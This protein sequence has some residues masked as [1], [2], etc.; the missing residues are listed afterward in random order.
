MTIRITGDG[1][2]R[3]HRYADGAASLAPIRRA[4]ADAFG[5]TPAQTRV[6]VRRLLRRVL[7]DVGGRYVDITAA[8]LDRIVSLRERIETA[9]QSVL[10]GDGGLPA[11]VT[12]ADV[13]RWLD[14]LDREM[15]AVASPRRHVE[16]ADV[17]L[18]ADAISAARRGDGDADAPDIDA[19]SGPQIAEA[20]PQIAAAAADLPEA[21]R[22]LVHAAAAEDPSLA[23]RIARGESASEVEAARQRLDG[24]LERAGVDVRDRR[25][26]LA[27]LD[28]A[29]R[30]HLAERR[31]ADR[32]AGQ[33]RID[34]ATG[35]VPAQEPTARAEALL[36]GLA[37]PDPDTPVGRA[38]ASLP[39]GQRDRLVALADE[40]PAAVRDLLDPRSTPAERA[41][42]LAALQ[43]TARRGA[44]HPHADADRIALAA[45]A[46]ADR[47]TPD[48]R[49][50]RAAPDPDFARALAS[51]PQSFRDRAAGL[52]FVRSLFEDWT[53]ARQPA[54][55]N[56]WRP[57]F[58][59]YVRG[60]MRA[61]VRGALGESTAA[62]ALGPN[63]IFLKVPKD[64]VT[65][66]GTDLVAID[67]D[68]GRV[69]LIDNKALTAPE[70]AR[71]RGDFEG[72]ATV[73][74]VTALTDNLER[75]LA[76]DLDA[77]RAVLHLPGTPPR[78]ADRVDGAIRRLDAALREIRSLPP[79][80]LPSAREA[81]IA[82]ILDRH[83][84]E[85][86][87]TNAAGDVDALSP[88]LQALGLVLRD[89][90]GGDGGDGP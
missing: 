87:V 5:M 17:A 47:A 72:S 8:R 28:D 68:T 7:E 10:S 78:I 88:R 44:G 85:R 4:A 11:G 9:F 37:E 70:G 56:R 12:V 48:V 6:F 42:A 83:A 27:R 46:E 69:L 62:F 1:L 52:P 30:A 51:A 24:A 18:P 55:P 21:A 41:T 16:H 43:D 76:D 14:E 75:N 84:I 57:T 3:L 20:G 15:D 64:R 31:A 82:R 38:W 89:L 61:H 58:A 65:D 86:T 34:E 74:S 40:N 63:A 80:L 23:R 33:R 79:E 73:A 54:G 90:E 39:Q 26:V 67:L 32:A 66:P 2:A 35:L 77:F 45:L 36:S 71:A 81:G 22:A 29:R 53:R 13:R 25:A 19:G 50:V 49:P 60:R 59:R